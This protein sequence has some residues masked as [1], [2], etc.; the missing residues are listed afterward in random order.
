MKN[1]VLNRNISKT[2]KKSPSSISVV[3]VKCSPD[4]IRKKAFELS[5]GHSSYDDYI[6][7]LAESELKFSKV[8]LDVGKNASDGLKIDTS[9]FVDKINEKEIRQLAVEYAKAH[10]S[11][12]DLHWYI[13]ERQC[14]LDS[15]RLHSS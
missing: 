6:W 15:A 8:C 12:Q 13:A 3:H 7:L 11:V 9:R 14:A 5:A 4:E 10:P 1:T 2:K